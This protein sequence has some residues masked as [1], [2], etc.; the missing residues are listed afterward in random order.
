M[1]GRK[2]QALECFER[3]LHAFE[4]FGMRNEAL[5]TH[6]RMGIVQ[7]EAGDY[8]EALYQLQTGIAVSLKKEETKR[9]EKKEERNI[10]K[11]RK[12]QEKGERTERRKKKEN[13]QE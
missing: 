4:R 9:K 1:S 2:D 11:K 3:A 12:G 6:E 8:E 10:K 7:S 5:F 13:N